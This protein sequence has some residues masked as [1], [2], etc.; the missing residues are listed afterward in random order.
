MATKKPRP[1]R[2]SRR[3]GAS[4]MTPG[5]SKS[6]AGNDKLIK[7]LREDL[8][9]HKDFIKEARK[10]LTV[11]QDPKSK[12]S[13]ELRSMMDQPRKKKVRSPHTDKKKSKY[14]DAFKSKG[15]LMVKPKAAKRGY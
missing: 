15:G 12:M 13:A 2:P 11:H 1:P 6:I 14:A 5:V 7:K 3:H 9:K 8:R 10:K 4:E